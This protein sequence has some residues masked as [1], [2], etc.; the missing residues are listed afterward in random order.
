MNGDTFTV[1]GAAATSF[2]VN[3][4]IN[5]I[6]TT[7]VSGGTVNVGFTTTVYPDGTFGYEFLIDDV[8]D[9]TT[10]SVNVGTSTI[11][12]TYVSGGIG[13]VGFTTTIFPDGTNGYEFDVTSVVNLSLI[14][15]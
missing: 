1:I 5:T 6:P 4:G 2:S 7:Y 8:I 10:L 9:T 13:T 14:H 3:V 11:T 12:H 15:I